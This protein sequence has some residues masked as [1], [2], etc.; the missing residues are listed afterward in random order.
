MTRSFM[1]LPAAKPLPGEPIE[2]WFDEK[3]KLLEEDEDLGPD[4]V[5]VKETPETSPSQQ[6]SLVFVSSLSQE[7]YRFLPEQDSD[8]E[9]TGN[10]VVSVLS[11]ELEDDHSEDDLTEFPIRRV[12][13]RQ[14]PQG[15]SRE[16]LQGIDSARISCFSPLYRG[17]TRFW[18]RE[19]VDEAFRQLQV[20][21]QVIGPED[22]LLKSNERVVL[23]QSQEAVLEGLVF[24][25]LTQYHP[26]L[27]QEKMLFKSKFSHGLDPKR[28][29]DLHW[30]FRNSCLHCQRRPKIILRPLGLTDLGTEARDPSH[31][32]SLCESAWVSLDSGRFPVEKVIPQV[33]QD[34]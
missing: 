13:S 12:T 1:D 24:L 27:T 32:L 21:H 14:R 5:H 28:F 9:D 34:P 7:E 33:R 8:E 26:S 19:E 6:I 31:T 22:S 11:A 15:L 10:E 29:E 23:G 17:M 25:H 16:V 2:D 18:E 20:K 3:L 4:I 30:R